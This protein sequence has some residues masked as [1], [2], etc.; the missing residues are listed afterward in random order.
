MLTTR[1]T[2][3]SSVAYANQS[4]W[5]QRRPGNA[6]PVNRPGVAQAHETELERIRSPGALVVMVNRRARPTRT[7]FP[8]PFRAG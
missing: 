2:A 7:V 1:T 3:V 6:A 4:E 8:R 5:Y